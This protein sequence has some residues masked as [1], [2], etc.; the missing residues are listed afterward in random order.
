MACVHA[1]K[2][3]STKIRWVRVWRRHKS[4]YRLAA[5]THSRTFDGERQLLRIGDVGPDT[6]RVSSG[7]LNLDVGQVE[8]SFASADKGDA[9]SETGKSERKTFSQSSSSAC[10]EDALSSKLG[11]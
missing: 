8:F 2:G 4:E 6:E 1:F 5:E 11:T 7:L 3:A 9:R 10:Y